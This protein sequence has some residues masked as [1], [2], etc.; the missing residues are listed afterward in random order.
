MGCSKESTYII[1]NEANL[2]FKDES[3][4]YQIIL[5][6]KTPCSSME[7]S[8]YRKISEEFN[9]KYLSIDDILYRKFKENINKNIII[10]I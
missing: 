5:I 1:K 2:I 9:Y 4:K 6:I 10:L 3:Q 8:L 7:S